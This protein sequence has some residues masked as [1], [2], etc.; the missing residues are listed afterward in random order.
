VQPAGLN[1][2]AASTIWVAGV[3]ALYAIRRA[4]SLL[5]R[6]VIVTGAAGGV[7]RLAVQLAVL[8]GAHV[9][10]IVGKSDE[11]VTAVRS[12][13]LPDVRIEHELSA[14]GERAHLILES[15]GGD[16]L[17]AALRRVAR[18][19]RVV[20]F[21]RSSGQPGVVPPEWF[22]RDAQ[23]DG[24]EFRQDAAVDV[25]SPSALGVLGALMASG[26]LEPGIG[27]RG[28]W[29]E[30]PSA[31]EALLARRVPGRIVLEVVGP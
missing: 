1:P 11:R 15:V 19:G 13:G 31:V 18:G 27:L 9:T 17:S 26:R 5:G 2:A 3:T 30:L 14:K 10:A 8:S 4:G 21:G 23:L 29:T 24:L 25:T 6:H 20:T 28:E 7:G 16:S 22:F 12:L